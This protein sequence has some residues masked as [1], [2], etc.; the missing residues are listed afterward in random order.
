MANGKP[1][2]PKDAVPAVRLRF[3][4]GYIH[5]GRDPEMDALYV[6]ITNLPRGSKFKSVAARLISGSMMESA[7]PESEV[8][9]IKKAADEIIANFVVDF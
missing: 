7:L 4:D 6:W 3:G 1:G 8:E 2:R 9:Q 5:L